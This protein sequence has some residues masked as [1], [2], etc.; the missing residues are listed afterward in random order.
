MP[1]L[2]YILTICTIETLSNIKSIFSLTIFF[3]LISALISITSKLSF[4]QRLRNPLQWRRRWKENKPSLK[5]APRLYGGPIIASW[6]RKSAYSANAFVRSGQRTVYYCPMVVLRSC[7]KWLGLQ[8]D[9][10]GVVTERTPKQNMLVYYS[11][12]PLC[13]CIVYLRRLSKSQRCVSIRRNSLPIVSADSITTSHSMSSTSRW[14]FPDI[15][16]LC[17]Q[18][19]THK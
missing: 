6:S 9:V 1:H 12:G 3:T 14:C 11:C 7:I 16:H 15:G 10:G 13:R 5:S 17:C 8:I 2:T 19:C 18:N 4:G